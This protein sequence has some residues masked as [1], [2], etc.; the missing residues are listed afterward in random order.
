MTSQHLES[1]ALALDG[2]PLIEFSLSQEAGLLQLRGT[3][4]AYEANLLIQLLR[5]DG[6]TEVVSVT[7]SVGAPERGTWDAAIESSDVTQIVI[8]QEEMGEGPGAATIR[9]RQ[10]VVNLA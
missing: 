1:T 10:V 4:V 7:A 9:D 8:R 5:R 2:R 3:A 6:T